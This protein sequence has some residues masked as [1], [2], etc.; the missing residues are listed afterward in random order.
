MNLDY[1]TSPSVVFIVT[2]V[3]LLAAFVLKRDAEQIRVHFGR[4]RL[5]RSR[6]R[7]PR[8]LGLTFIIDGR[9]YTVFE[10]LDSIRSTDYKNTEV[11][12]R[13]AAAN[14]KLNNKLRYYKRKYGLSTMKLVSSRR[15]FSD[16][17]LVARYARRSLVMKL[18]TGY[19]VCSGAVGNISQLFNDTNIEAAAVGSYGLPDSRLRS[20]MISLQQLLHWYRLP[21]KTSSSR[22]A[23]LQ[24]M[25]V[26]RKRSLERRTPTKDEVM[27]RLRS[28]VAVRTADRRAV[29][30]SISRLALLASTCF[31]AILASTVVLEGIV[32]LKALLAYYTATTLIAMMVILST[33]TPRL[34]WSLRIS[35]VLIAP[36]YPFAVLVFAFSQY[37]VRMV[38]VA[39]NIQ[40]P[41]AQL[42]QVKQKLSTTW[43]ALRA[44]SGR[45]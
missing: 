3:L 37:T 38:R 4:A 11:I 28:M 8:K 35:L 9:S 17:T 15:A 24:N 25:V 18:P 2:Y 43:S 12:V 13:Y 34:A 5:L 7:S 29:S 16:E 6:E 19:T 21:E 23:S 26:Y 22:S 45:H 44:Y 36:F 20:A 10:T 41:K 33:L 42:M 31:I 27:H 40:L 32:G 1:L 30:L 39:K 14:T